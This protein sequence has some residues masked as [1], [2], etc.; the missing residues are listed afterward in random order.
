MK[1]C[2]LLAPPPA[3]ASSSPS[4]SPPAPNA[5][6]SSSS[7][8]VPVGAVVGGIAGAAGVHVYVHALLRHAMRQECGQECGHARMA[9]LPLAAPLS[10]LSAVVVAALSFFALRPGKGWL[11]RRPPPA[12]LEGGSGGLETPELLSAKE[13]ALT[14]PEP[15]ALTKSAV[16]GSASAQGSLGPLPLPLSYISS[17]GASVR[18]AAAAQ[19]ASGHSASLTQ[20]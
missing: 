20:R 6:S 16:V 3:D 12:T 9:Q 11:R 17:Q 19:P 2:A 4:T 13:V 5:P 1:A 15:Q 14:A 8:S 10:C 18:D 7:S